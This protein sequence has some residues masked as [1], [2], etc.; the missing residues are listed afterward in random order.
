LTERKPS[1]KGKKSAK[2]S[3]KI[4]VESVQP[5]D[6]LQPMEMAP[7][8]SA[9]PSPAAEPKV[10]EQP[11]AP[12][13]PQAGS[14]T[15]TSDYKRLVKLLGRRS[16]DQ[17]IDA[18]ADALGARV[19]R[20]RAGKHETGIAFQGAGLWF[21]SDGGIITG[22]FVEF[23]DAEHGYDQY[24]GNLGLG[25]TQPECHAAMQKLAAE[26]MESGKHAQRGGPKLHIWER[27]RHADTELRFNFDEQTG[28]LHNLSILLGHTADQATYRPIGPNF[29]VILEKHLSPVAQAVLVRARQEAHR[30]DHDEIGTEQLLIALLS[31]ESGITQELF[32]RFNLRAEHARAEVDK[33]L[34][35]GE[36]KPGAWMSARLRSVILLAFDEAAR[37]KAKE[38]DDTHLL[39][40]LLHLRKGFAIRVLENLGIE[41]EALQNDLVQ[42]LR[43]R[44]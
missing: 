22:V 28:K 25:E 32:H 29:D 37:L 39:L 17:E 41:I 20:H 7:F 44:S 1:K 31:M 35:R 4:P 10:I 11:A 33:M 2:A 14:P 19:Q 38:I 40:A 42:T 18:L 43:S 30:L 23:R 15:M 3:P 34:P 13:L 24:T 36:G 26:Y 21:I 9:D 27:Y 12:A 16:D 8:R 6:A 5:V